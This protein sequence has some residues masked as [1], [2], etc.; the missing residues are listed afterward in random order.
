MWWVERGRFSI[1]F[2]SEQLSLSAT[3]K[4][5]VW[6]SS[7]HPHECPSLQ[8]AQQA[9][10]HHWKYNWCS[11]RSV[12]HHFQWPLYIPFHTV[13]SSPK[14]NHSSIRLLEHVRTIQFQFCQI[15]IYVSILM[16][17]MP[18]YKT[19]NSLP[20]FISHCLSQ[21]CLFVKFLLEHFSI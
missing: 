11:S 10:V 21:Y 17:S 19:Y 1:S 2:P 15:C 14:I 9:W 7:Q 18:Q 4:Q 8:T 20:F 5:N 3:L 12:L 13:L 16:S 6:E